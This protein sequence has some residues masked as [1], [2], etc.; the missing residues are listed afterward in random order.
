M[1]TNR[2][3]MCPIW[4]LQPTNT[5]QGSGYWAVGEVSIS[6]GYCWVVGVKALVIGQSEKLF[7]VLLLAV[8]VSVRLLL[9]VLLLQSYDGCL[10]WLVWAVGGFRWLFLAGQSVACA[11]CDDWLTGLQFVVLVC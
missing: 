10:D 5:G 6:V 2:G 9:V 7:V 4:R 3:G 8:L 1:R 11:G